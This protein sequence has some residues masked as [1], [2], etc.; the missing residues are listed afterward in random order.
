MVFRVDYVK[1]NEISKKLEEHTEDLYNTFEDAIKIVENLN[2]SW[3]GT[4]YDNF[5]EVSTTYIKNLYKSIDELNYIASFLNT[6]SNTYS[7]NDNEWAKD[8]KKI[9]VDDEWD[10]A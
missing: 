8:L 10:K 4:D 1:L 6:A 7:K 5:K 9:G 2:N 3:K